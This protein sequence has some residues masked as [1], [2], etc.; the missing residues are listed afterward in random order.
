MN[1]LFSYLRSR[2]IA[3]AMLI[4]W[5][6][7]LGVGFANACPVHGTDAARKEPSRPSAGL[8]SMALAAVGLDA[9]ADG[10][11]MQPHFGAGAHHIAPA[12]FGCQ[13]IRA[14][15]QIGGATSPIAK[16]KHADVEVP[17]N[18]TEQVAVPPHIG[19]DPLPWSLEFLT[20]S[21]PPIFIRFLRLTI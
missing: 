5:T 16:P 10:L 6:L 3:A 12:D 7:A 19:N 1:H 18:W 15:G 20:W 21:Q 8:P 9:L 17:L 13:S 11:A 2:A 14:A 4:I